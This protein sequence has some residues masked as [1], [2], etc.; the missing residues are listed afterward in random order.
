MKVADSF[1]QEHFKLLDDGH[2][3]SET[4]WCCNDGPQLFL[5]SVLRVF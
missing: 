5:T 2:T 1:S 3:L 4:R